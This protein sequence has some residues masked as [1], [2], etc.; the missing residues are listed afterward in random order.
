MNM[1]DHPRIISLLDLLKEV[2]DNCI[3]ALKAAIPE[4]EN[5]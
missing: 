1:L 4:K 2:V 5:D 3:I